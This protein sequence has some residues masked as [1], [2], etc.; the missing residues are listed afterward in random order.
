[1]SRYPSAQV[2][3]QQGSVL[4][5]KTGCLVWKR[6]TNRGGYGVI[7]LGN[8]SWIAHRAAYHLSV[9]EIP[10]GLV[11]DHLCRNTLCV[12]PDHLEPVT[13]RENIARAHA[14]K[15]HCKRGHAFDSENTYLWK[16]NR[17]CRKCNALRSKFFKEGY[18]V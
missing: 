17:H 14:A 4:D 8:R 13:G 9:G 18:R 11:L 16:G 3:L 2:R 12:N 15:T 7:R 1:M 10:P 6:A 5:P